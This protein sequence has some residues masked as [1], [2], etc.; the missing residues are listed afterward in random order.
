MLSLFTTTTKY[1]E[2]KPLANYFV[3]TTVTQRIAEFKK[4]SAL[5][6]EKYPII[7]ISEDPQLQLEKQKYMVVKTMTFGEFAAIIRARLTLAPDT[8]LFYFVGKYKKCVHHSQSIGELAKEYANEDDK[9]LA[10]YFRGESA[11]G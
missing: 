3:D 1:D 4:V 8:A 7:V 2:P 10:I 9:F 11:F 6:P 5:Y